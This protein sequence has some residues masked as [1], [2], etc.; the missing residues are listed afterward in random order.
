MKFFRLINGVMLSE[1][2]AYPYPVEWVT[3]A[4]FERELIKTRESLARQE[5]N[6]KPPEYRF[7]N[8]TCSQCGGEFGPGDNG[9]SHCE[10]HKH[11]PRLG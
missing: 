1:E 8:V 11:L 2:G 6:A 7:N 9:F 10:N 5:C 4:D 3:R